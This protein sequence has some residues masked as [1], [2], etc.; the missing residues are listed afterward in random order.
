MVGIDPDFVLRA[1]VEGFQHVALPDPAAFR[2]PILGSAH[3]GVR[4]P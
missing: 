1:S 2:Y 4:E 3:G